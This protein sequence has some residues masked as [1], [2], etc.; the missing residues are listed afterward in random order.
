MYSL[1]KRRSSA[2]QADALTRVRETHKKCGDRN[3]SG[4]LREL[5]LNI[6]GG[7]WNPSEGEFERVKKRGLV[8]CHPDKQVRKTF[9]EQCLFEAIFKELNG[10]T[11]K[12]P[13]DRPGNSVVGQ[14]MPRTHTSP[15]T[16]PRPGSHYRRTSIHNGAFSP[17]SSATG[18]D[19][20]TDPVALFVPAA[21]PVDT[22]HPTGS[23]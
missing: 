10:W 1:C 13:L 16:I 8:L 20:A 9:R 12:P 17:G 15:P 3:I 19:A 2:T 5:G 14:V 6:E 4:F 11:Y 21:A 18:N 22:D 7:A 23:R